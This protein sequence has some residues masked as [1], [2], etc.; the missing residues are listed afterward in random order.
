M[1]HWVAIGLH[2]P[3]GKEKST[4]EIQKNGISE[5]P[6]SAPLEDVLNSYIGIHSYMYINRYFINKNTETEAGRGRRDE[7]QLDANRG[8]DH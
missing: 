5:K 7:L 1:Q 3:L 2:K 8:V 6:K 4:C